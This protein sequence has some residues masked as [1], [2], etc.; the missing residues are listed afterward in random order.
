PAAS[1][2]RWRQSATARRAGHGSPT[3]GP[4]VEPMSAPSTPAPR[5][6][7]IWAGSLLV[8]TVVAT[9][10]AV[11]VG[12]AAVAYEAGDPG[13]LVR[14]G[15]PGVTAVHDVAAALTVGFLLVGAFL[16]PETTRTRRRLLASRAASLAGSVWILT[17]LL[18]VVLTFADL[19]GV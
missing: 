1:V 3:R 19:A 6:S 16:V 8:A 5:G 9:V 17:L 4:R 14:W 11:V 15:I 18:L 2:W 13:A 10:L 12:S 7:A